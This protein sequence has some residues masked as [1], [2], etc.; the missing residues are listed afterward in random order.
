MREAD[1]FTTYIDFAVRRIDRTELF[2]RLPDG[3]VEGARG[4]PSWFAPSDHIREDAPRVFARPTSIAGVK[5]VARLHYAEEDPRLRRISIVLDPLQPCATGAAASAIGSIFDLIKA[6]AD[7]LVR[8]G[9]ELVC[10]ISC[11][12][13]PHKDGVQ[14]VIDIVPVIPPPD[15][16]PSME[17]FFVYYD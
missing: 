14:P 5:G 3:W 6:T 15:E 10:M 7:L 12:L 9:S 8:D 16:P 2:R 4:G 17:Q 1:E 11:G 13:H